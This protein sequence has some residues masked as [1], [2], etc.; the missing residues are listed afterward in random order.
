MKFLIDIKNYFL[1]KKRKFFD[2]KFYLS[3]YSDVRKADINP[4]WH[5]VTKGYKEKR[6]PNNLINWE[7]YY[8][9]NDTINIKKILNFIIHNNNSEIVLC[10]YNNDYFFNNLDF[11]EL[12]LV[13]IIILTRNGEN[14]IKNL[15]KGLKEN[16]LYPN[17]EIIIVDNNST[18][19]TIKFLEEN[20]Y[21]FNLKI[22]KNKGN[23]SFSIGNNDAVNFSKGKLL[24]FLNNDVFPIKGWLCELVREYLNNP[25][26]GSAGSKL[27][28]PKKKGFNNSCKIQHSGIA[29]RYEGEFYKPYNM[30]NGADVSEFNKKEKRAAL[31]AACLLVE[32]NKFLEVGGF[33]EKYIYGYEDVDLGL[34]LLKQGYENIYIPS[35]MLYHYEFGTQHKDSN[36]EVK[37]RRL[38]NIKHF[39]KKWNIYIKKRYWEEKI[40]NKNF[41]FS[42][43][44]LH[45]AFAVSNK[46]D[47]IAEGDYFTAL[48]LAKEFEKFGW[49]VSFLSRK[50]KEWYNLNENIDLLIT[51][52]DSYD[53]NKIKTNKKVITI[54]WARN[55]FDR[56]V[57]NRSFNNYDF[58]FASSQKAC[59]FIKKHSNKDAILFPI[60]TNEKRFSQKEY[61]EK[62][63]CDYCFTGSYWNDKRDIIEKLNPANLPFKFHIYGKNW[64]KIDKF[65]PYFKGF[66]NYTDMPKVYS[67]TK[68]VIDD[69]NRVTKPFASVNSRVFD[70]FG[71]G[72]LVITNGKLGSLELFDGKLPYYESSEELEELLNKYLS[73]EQSRKNKIEELQKF[74]LTNHT[75][76]V[77]AKFFKN[78]LKD[79]F[80]K[81]SIIINIP[82]P[83]WEV[84][85]EWGDFY[86]AKSL[87]KYFIRRGYRCEIQILPD[88]NNKNLFEDVVFVL[89]GLSKY[90]IRNY[91]FNIMWNISHPDKIEKFE[92]DSFDYVYI[93]SNYWSEHIKDILKKMNSSTFVSPL[94]QCTDSE[95]FKHIDTKED[96]DIL[97]VG[98]SRKVFRKII[99]DL[100]PIKYDVHI[101]G[102]LW[103][104]FI[105]NRY[106]KGVNIPN[107]EL[108]KYY[109]RAK[110]V[111]NDHWEDMKEKGFISNRIFDVSACAKFI[112]TDE[113]KGLKDIFGDSIVS[114]NGSREDLI[115]KI[116]TYIN[117]K[118][119]REE[120]AKKAQKIVLK[121]HTFDKRVEEIDNMLKEKCY[122][123]K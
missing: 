100:L 94:L 62:Y 11:K 35:S 12:P 123:E 112:I 34:K 106:I 14:Y 44:P 66:I 72:V 49:N 3:K 41:L 91:H 58:V 26:L 4:L 117:N 38:N 18:D 43:K 45:I 10:D 15:F 99:K 83:K 121:Y 28:Y 67:N 110:I 108:Y 76:N 51:L 65:K 74:I 122:Y 29:F 69:A 16:T 37:Q 88:W 17:F 27:I 47:N 25:K 105:D 63:K 107:D 19:N 102:T 22:I 40:E 80:I 57:K 8:N 104:E 24:L 92:Y 20:I 36:N 85:K 120:K 13:S 61:D 81:K 6:W 54:A 1:I 114:Y 79:I 52:I 46:G 93:S 115:N 70:A 39:Q 71:S 23:K 32:K 68:I 118:N 5:F 30:G 95:V 96:I 113:V 53:I 42:E 33:D 31:T 64:E 78:F 89:R 111:L 75:Y 60:A 56:W 9:L 21:N 98:N 55:W 116:E 119:L 82:V 84:A 59:E 103:E 2:E 77:R 87:K 50:H 101:Y 109:N 48:E 73:N 7:E 90:N 86:F 97:F